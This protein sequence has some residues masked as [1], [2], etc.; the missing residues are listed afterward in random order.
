MPD[1]AGA[2]V[3]TATIVALLATLAIGA[4]IGVYY[5]GRVRKPL[6]LSLHLVLGTLGIALLLWRLPAA[7]GP[8]G[9]NAA[10]L[11]AAAVFLGLMARLVFRRSRRLSEF[12]LVTHVFAGIAGFLVFLSWAATL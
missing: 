9:S 4:V 10:I 8:V 6:L 3:K 7:P 5:L 12:L 1:G 2:R 11:L